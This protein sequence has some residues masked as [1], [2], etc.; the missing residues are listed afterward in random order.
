MEKRA[1]IRSLVDRWSVSVVLCVGAV[2]L[3]QTLRR[4]GRQPSQD[5]FRRAARAY[6]QSQEAHPCM[7]VFGLALPA[8]SR[9][10]GLQAQEVGFLAAERLR[11]FLSTRP[12]LNRSLR[13]GRYQA[14]IVSRDA[15]D[16]AVVDFAD[17]GKIAR[18]VPLLDPAHPV[19]RFDA[20]SSAAAVAAVAHAYDRTRL[21][22]DKRR[23]RALAR[24]ALRELGKG[25][26]SL[27]D[28]GRA[29][30]E[31]VDRLLRAVWVTSEVLPDEPGPVG[32]LDGNLRVNPPALR[33][34]MGPGPGGLVVSVRITP[35]RNAADLWF[36]FHH[37]LFDGVPF[38]EMLADLERQ[39]G[40][41]A[42]LVLPALGRAAGSRPTMLCSG[43]GA[44]ECSLAQDWLDFGPLLSA[45]RRLER[46]YKDR[47]GG[48][49][50]SSVALLIWQLAQQRSFRDIKFTVVLDVPATRKRERTLGIASIRPQLF[51]RDGASDEAFLRFNKELIERIEGTRERRSASYELVESFALLPAW[52]Y[53]LALRLLGRGLRE[54]LGTF[55]VSVIRETPLV[56]AA[57]PDIHVDGFL[58]IGRFDMPTAD[59]GLAGIVMLKGPSG[60]LSG[61]TDSVRSAIAALA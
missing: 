21:L 60:K 26:G 43:P 12:E 59:G 10:E 4:L 57:Q 6:F 20:S 5:G 41:A 8:P 16:A 58:G 39:W 25:T 46:L 56:I 45:R 42:P 47:L 24:E 34:H 9:S 53:P 49:R 30:R 36:Q 38:A 61:Y 14:R 52:I 55:G 48:E 19:E 3:L 31:V 40:V 13:W 7:P 37:A 11:E 29:A 54:C 32:E 33:A 15:C 51:L 44:P 50:V 28:G 1:R 18:L 27:P 23:P 35:G 22:S 17:D 2:K